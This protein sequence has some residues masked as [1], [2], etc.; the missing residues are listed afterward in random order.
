M[1]FRRGENEFWLLKVEPAVLGA[2]R[3]EHCLT[4]HYTFQKDPSLKEHNIT[5]QFL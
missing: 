4:I 1:N 2:K 5:R 3:R